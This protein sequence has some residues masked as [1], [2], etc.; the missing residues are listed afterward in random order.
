VRTVQEEIEKIIKKIFD[1]NIT[2]QCSGRTDA[3]VHAIG[4]TFS[5]NVKKSKINPKALLLA[6]RSS[7]P[8]DIYFVNVKQVDGMFNARFS[9]KN[10]TYQYVI[11]TS[12][13]DLFKTNYEL[14]YPTKINLTL[15]KK[16]S[17]L[18]V[19]EHDFKSFSTSELDNTIRKIN[20]IKFKKTKTHLL[21]EVNGNGFLRNMVRMIIGSFID[22]NEGKKTIL[23]IKNLLANPQKGSAINKIQAKGL[24]LIK[25][26]Y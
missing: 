22:L 5:F 7:G 18:L 25:V 23:D 12:K 13:Y 6:L 10:K 15:L 19:G 26:N 1:Q 21:V 17:K 20:Y 9:A 8:T 24:Y 11:N 16:A 14:Y 4:Q 2:I 3:Y